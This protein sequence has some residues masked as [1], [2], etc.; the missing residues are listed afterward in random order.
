M[1]SV[2]ALLYGA[3]LKTAFVGLFARR[4]AGYGLVPN[5]EAT[6]AILRLHIEL[7]LEIGLAFQDQVR[8]AQ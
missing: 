6:A 3:H 4:A 5:A 7:V 2:D 8:I 1:T